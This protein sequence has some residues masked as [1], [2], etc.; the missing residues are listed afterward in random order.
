M[1]KVDVC[2]ALE[3]TF[4]RLFLCIQ[5]FLTMAY[6]PS[7][8]GVPF[9]DEGKGATVYCHQLLSVEGGETKTW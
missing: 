9:S 3:Y 8:I 6:S 1:R 5:L 4:Q 2:T 7:I